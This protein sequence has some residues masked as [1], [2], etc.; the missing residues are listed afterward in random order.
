MTKTKN[1]VLLHGWGANV[2]K[3]RPLS[4]ELERFGWT[5]QLIKLPGFDLPAPKSD[6]QLADFARFV[7]DQTKFPKYYLFGHSFGGRVAVKLAL[8]QPQSISGLVLCA[9]GGF[10]R[11]NSFRR[12]LFYYLAKIGKFVVGGTA[13]TSISRKFI[14]KLAR[15]HDYEK[16]SGVMKDV[17]KKIVSEDLR[18]V[19]G[20]IRMPVLILWGSS[21]TMLP[22]AGAHFLKTHLKNAKVVLFDKAGH[23]L[24]YDSPNKV[25]KEVSKWSS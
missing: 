5:V 4:K 10:Y 16:A 7:S 1:I 18:Q 22:V 11:P 20:E 9:P 21:D 23:T 13:L 14:Y 25:A 24:P 17:F 15:E 12:H 8:Q 2:N 6:W 19:V 3:L